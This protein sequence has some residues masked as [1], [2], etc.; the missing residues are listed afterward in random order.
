MSHTDRENSS[1][2]AGKGTFSF[3]QLPAEVRDMIYHHCLTSE[4][5]VPRYSAWTKRWTPIDLLY[6]NRTIYNEAFFHLYTKGEFVLVIRPESLFALASCWATN[7]I[8]ASVGLELFFKT[9]RILDLIRHIR[10]EIH[11]PSVQYSTLMD[12]K[13]SRRAPTTDNMLKRTIRTTGAMLSE[14]PALRTIDVSWYHMTVCPWELAKVAP[15]D[16]KIPVWLRGL[17]QV[18]RK[19]EKVLIR[20]PSTGPVSTEELAQGQGDRD[21]LANLL[22][23]VREDLQELKG[24]LQERLY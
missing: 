21:E 5:I 18:R 1:S 23:E 12:R 19:D 6:V 24:C 8:S 3:L 2:C 9:K 15:P 20:M 17:K 10:L 4:T 16:Y 11:W 13:I 7:D 22:K 14:L